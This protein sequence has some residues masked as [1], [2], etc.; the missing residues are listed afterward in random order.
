MLDV[1]TNRRELIDDDL[2]SG[3]AT[4]ERSA[5]CTTRSSGAMWRP[6]PSSSRALL[7]WRTSRQATRAAFLRRYQG[8][9][10]TFNDDIQGT[11]AVNLAPCS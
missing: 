2:Y 6:P 11:G 7:H 10:L 9:I 4:P 1:G 5:T 3:P 8:E